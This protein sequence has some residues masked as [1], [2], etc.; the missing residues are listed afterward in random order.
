MHN[1]KIVYTENVKSI[2]GDSND[3]LLYQSHISDKN[4]RI[5]KLIGKI[6]TITCFLQNTQQKALFD[7]GAQ[8]SV[9]SENH[10]RNSFP[11]EK[12]RDIS[13]LL[14]S[15]A[16]LDLK[17][18]NG[19]ALPYIGYVV[20]LFSFKEGEPG[21]KVPMLVTNSILDLPIIGYNVLEEIITSPRNDFRH[22]LASLQFSL[23]QDREED[24]TTLINVIR[25]A[26]DERPP[27][28]KTSKHKVIIPKHSTLK[29]NCRT[30]LEPVSKDSMFLFE[31]NDI[32]TWPEGLEIMQELILLRQNDNRISVRVHNSTSRDLPLKG[33][34]E[35]GRLEQ[36]RSVTELQVKQKTTM[37]ENSVNVSGISCVKSETLDVA[38]SVDFDKLTAK[39]KETALK[40][41]REEVNAFSANDSDV[42]NIPDL[43]L[44]INLT[45]EFPVQKSYVN[46][47]K[48]LFSEVKNYIEDLLNRGFISKSKS[49]YSSPVLCVRKKDGTL[50]LCID[51]R[52]LN[53]K[54]VPDKHPLPRIQQTVENLGGNSWFTLLDM[55]KAYHQGYVA[56][57]SRHKTAFVTPWGLYEWERI[58]FGLT[59]APS[60]FQRFMEDCLSGLQDEIFVPYLDDVIVFSKTFEEHVEHL[61]IVLNRLSSR[62]VKLKLSKC[63][64]FQ[65]E[66]CYLGHVVLEYGYKPNTSKLAAVTSLSERPPKNIGELR[67]LIGLLSYYRKYIPGF[68]KLAKPLTDLLR[69]DRDGEDN[70]TK[71]AHKKGSSKGGQ[72]PSAAEIRWGS[73][74]QRSLE[75]L[76]NCLTSP[77]ILAYPD[78]SRDFVL[79]TDASQDGLGAVLYQEDEEGKLRVVGYG[80]LTL[81]PAEK[82]YHM[83]ARK[84][85]FLAL[86]W[87]I[88]DHFR[89]YLYYAPHFTVFTDNNPLTYV[90]STAKLNATGYRW[91]AELADFHF[92]I[93]YRPG[94]CNIDADALSRLPYQYQSSCTLETSPDTIHAIVNGV[95]AQ[96]AGKATW[97][98]A[99]STQTADQDSNRT[100]HSLSLAEIAD[101]QR[102]D[103]DISRVMELQKADKKPSYA[104]AKAET[105]S[106]KLLLREWDKLSVTKQ[107]ILQRRSGD[108]HQLVLP[109]KYCP[110]VLR[111]LH[112]NMGHLGADRVFDL[113]RERFYWPRMFT[114]ISVYVTKVCSCLKTKAP[115]TH[116][117]APLQ[118]IVSTMPLEL[119]SVDFLHLE[120]SQ[121]GYEYILVI[122]D[123]FTRFAQAYPTRNKEAKTAAN[124]LFND[125]F[126]RFGFPAKILHDQGREFENKL[127]RELE[128]LAGITRLRT[129]P[130][131][132]QGNGQ[133]ERFNK[134]LLGMLRTLSNSD[135]LNWKDSL[136]KMTHAYNTTR[137]SATGYSPF[138]LMFGRKPKLSIDIVFSQAAIGNPASLR[139]V[140]KW[141]NEISEAR[142]IAAEHSAK[143]RA[144]AKTQ[145]DKKVHHVLLIPGDRVLIRN[146]TPKEGPSKLRSYWED[147]VHVVVSQKA[148]SPVYIVKPESGEGRE[149]T[150]HR[151]LLLPC[152]LLVNSEDSKEKNRRQATHSRNKPSQSH[153][154]NVDTEDSDT[155]DI[156][157]FLPSL[158]Y[159]QQASHSDHVLTNI[160]ANVQESDEVS[161]CPPSPTNLSPLAQEFSPSS[162][163]RASSPDEPRRFRPQR[164][165][166]APVLLTYNRFG[167]PSTVQYAS[168]N[169]LQLPW[170]TVVYRMPPYGHHGYSPFLHYCY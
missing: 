98:A 34:L 116:T 6:C 8:V 51:Y 118:N 67:K 139:S 28:V 143:S 20:L 144:L 74:H 43:Q 61:H 152:N 56:E 71:L 25:E 104:A 169:S 167:S 78:F 17:T 70:S 48:P 155:D 161:T 22:L 102:Q 31:P 88:C 15:D 55:N 94:H 153:S 117:R 16:N 40:M 93:R 26:K 38:A 106:V 113:A 85:E 170:P 4:N 44:E 128:K 151:N 133:T 115:S 50:R 23:N 10:L 91:I 131:H 7:T 142:R 30:N 107:G 36:I 32:E 89:D 96:E 76:V 156:P 166:N 18:A 19:S 87:S 130:Y 157:L 120:R 119:V 35:I 42:D 24:I 103:P 5:I 72:L 127:F 79:H 84:L 114:Q 1:R 65:R 97:V 12:V 146:L 14:G 145:H 135:K 81:T 39:Q 11:R 147:T 129:T 80:S 92:K 134:T 62:G 66:V 77:P 3:K 136:N 90:L 163:S 27:C 126:L 60:V 45:D 63:Q 57:N 37:E 33:R 125:F 21:I 47:P 132:P 111:E 95:H 140:N 100:L 59:N 124:K 158:P 137:N 160:D 101:A 73:N 112:N 75:A 69:Q 58:P 53:R 149:R 41:L 54:T 148:E 49:A 86:K 105:P 141:H 46:V 165:R 168:V 68:A 109:K 122:V 110:L 164:T 123:N 82:G 52:A 64:F 162:V 29:V 108:T 9:I 150:L 83:H 121:G 2:I 159:T 138:F 99:V 13:E 154:I